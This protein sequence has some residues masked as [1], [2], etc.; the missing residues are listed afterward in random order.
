MVHSSVMPKGVMYSGT[1]IRGGHV[2]GVFGDRPR[3]HVFGVF[4]YSG[5]D[6]GFGKSD[7]ET[8]ICF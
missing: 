1:C 5:T 3:F 4:V 6:H 2:F 7:R 8:L